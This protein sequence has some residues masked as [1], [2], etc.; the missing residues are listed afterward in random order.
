VQVSDVASVEG[1][2]TAEQ[3]QAAVG[4]FG[5][6]LRNRGPQAVSL[7]LTV[8][9]DPG[10]GRGEAEPATV[11]LDPG[12]TATARVTAHPRRRLV[13]GP[14][15]YGVRVTGCDR[16]TGGE[17]VTVRADATA[18]ARAGVP[19][20]VV[21]LLVLLAAGAAAAWLAGLRLPDRG[22]AAPAPAATT[23]GD[24]RRPYVMVDAYPQLDPSVRARADASLARLSAAGLQVRLVDSRQSDELA[25]GASGFW[26]IL[27][28]GFGSVEEANQFCTGN[29]GV[30]PR[31]EVVP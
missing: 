13:G 4:R 27:R 14:A 10:G 17:V 30:T 8:R 9:L 11:D 25:D 6:W 7:A 2:L 1:T 24:V 19:L 22:T 15:A 31:C 3:G 12:R 20:A 26:V 18:P 16:A 28:D 21:L 23:G 29:Q 5:L